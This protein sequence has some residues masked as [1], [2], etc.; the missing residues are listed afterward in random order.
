MWRLPVPRT[1]PMCPMCSRPHLAWQVSK[2][3]GG[4]GPCPQVLLGRSAAQ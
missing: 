3:P 1:R 2:M 4:Q